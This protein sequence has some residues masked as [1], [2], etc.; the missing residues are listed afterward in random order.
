M[1]P[2]K[3]FRQKWVVPF[4]IWSFSI[5]YSWWFSI[6]NIW[7]KSFKFHMFPFHISD[8]WF[9]HWCILH[10]MLALPWLIQHLSFSIKE[11]MFTLNGLHLRVCFPHFFQQNLGETCKKKVLDWKTCELLKM[12]PYLGK[13]AMSTNIAILDT[14][15]ANYSTYS[16]SAPLQLP[17][18]GGRIQQHHCRFEWNISPPRSTED[19][20][21]LWGLG[22]GWC[23]IGVGKS[24]HPVVCG[25][26]CDEPWRDWGPSV[27]T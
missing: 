11:L 7:R 15:N 3:S 16:H 6:S 13:I 21:C 4:H 8:S 24:W 23:N 25:G 5:P 18:P 14:T 26:W 12:H 27:L 22:M 9:H 17:R 10:H 1:I 19:K 2:P 20:I